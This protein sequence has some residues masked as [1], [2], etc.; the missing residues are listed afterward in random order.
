MFV[1]SAP[2]YDLMYS[3]LDYRSASAKLG[4][5]IHERHPTAKT[6]LDVACGTGRHLEHLGRTFEVSGLDINPELL[7]IAQARCPG[8]PLHQG[9]MV[10]FD[11]SERFD[12]VT[13]LFS[14]IA[15]TRTR[16]RMARAVA[17]MARHLQPTGIL[18]IEP[19]F[20]PERFWADH[21]ITN[22]AREKD[23]HVAWMY[24]QR[25]LGDLAVLDIHYLVGTPRGIERF[26]EHH[27]M[28]LF[29]D[30]E[31]AAALQAAGLTVEHDHEGP[32]GRGLFLG[33]PDS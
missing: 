24:V 8:V 17:T 26:E 12:V 7:A 20:P 30:E 29:R 13:C 15:Y 18:M 6:L 31:I 10:D 14:S 33:R 2:L 19:F 32:F 4:E 23:R 21:V 11:L 28:G 9:D 16:A 5:L 25:R 22:V 27:E 3:F 1:R